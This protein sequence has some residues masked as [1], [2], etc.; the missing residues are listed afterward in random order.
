MNLTLLIP[1]K[2]EKI[3]YQLKQKKNDLKIES[4]PSYER[5]RLADFKKVNPIKDGCCILVKM[6][7]LYFQ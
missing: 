6:I 7:S 4:Y 3:N 2:F 5:K 1:A